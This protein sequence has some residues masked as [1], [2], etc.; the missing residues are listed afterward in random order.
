M[1]VAET[2][3]A[4]TGRASEA[5]TETRERTERDLLALDTPVVSLHVHRPHLHLP[6]VTTKPAGRAV[7]AARNVLPTPTRL[8]YYGGL[9]AMA[10]AGVIEWPVAVAIGLG[11]AIGQRIRRNGRPA[12]DAGDERAE[13]RTAGA[14]RETRSETEAKRE[15][16][17]RP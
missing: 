7:R 15:A 3:E 13:E 1:T 17:S 14:K 16:K 2:K 10:V 12:A 8:V 5:R 9:G 6:G 4:T 11:T